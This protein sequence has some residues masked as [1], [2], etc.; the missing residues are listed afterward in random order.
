MAYVKRSTCVYGCMA[1][2]KHMDLDMVR[3]GYTPHGPHMD[4]TWAF[5]VHATINIILKLKFILY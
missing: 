3:M 5:F 2:V 1:Y 4:E